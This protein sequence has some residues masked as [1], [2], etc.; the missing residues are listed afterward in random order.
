[1]YGTVNYVTLAINITFHPLLLLALTR[2]VGS[3]GEKNTNAVIAGLH[4]IVYE[5][6]VRQIHVYPAYTSFAA[7]FAILY[8]VI[9][10]GIF[11]GIIGILQS[12]EFNN[13]SIALFL[14]FLALVTY[15][16]FR[17]RRNAKRWQISGQESGFTLFMHVLV[18]PVVRVGHWLSRTYSSI[19][20]LVLFMDFIIEMPFKML[21]NFSH[22]FLV[23]LK[24]KA[25]EVY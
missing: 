16:S 25:D 14:F 23:Y 7:L 12:F 5:N 4:G 19:N 24:D 20:I 15:L 11:G 6:K 10:C 3:L 17:I 18:A 1:M 9:I 21:L 2:G 13:A 22:H 8:L